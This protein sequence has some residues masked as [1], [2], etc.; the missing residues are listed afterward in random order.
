MTIE[1]KVAAMEAHESDI[2]RQISEIKGE[3]KD[4]RG[5][6]AAIERLAVSVKSMSE[7]VDKIDG[8]LAS[9]ESEPADEYRHYKRLAIGGIITGVIGWLFA[10]ITT[11]VK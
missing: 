10:L 11:L 2:D 1:E 4:L 9:V 6:T 7:K 3:L 5:L 8:R